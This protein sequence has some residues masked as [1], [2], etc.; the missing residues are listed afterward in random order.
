MKARKNNKAQKAYRDDYSHSISKSSL[1]HGPLQYVELEDYLSDEDGQTPQRL[2]FRPVPSALMLPIQEQGKPPLEKWTLMLQ[3][4]AWC[5]VDPETRNP[6]MTKDEW[7]WMDIKLQQF[8]IGAILGIEFET[9]E[10]GEE[11]KIDKLELEQAREMEE[12]AKDPNPL[13]ETTGTDSLTHS[14]EN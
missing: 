12:L 9:D 11:D 7:E 2:Y 14:T 4:L 13:D 10:D 3:A 1:Q 8:A 6:I 5:V